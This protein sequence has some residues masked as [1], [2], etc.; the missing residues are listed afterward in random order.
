MVFLGPG[1]DL[2]LSLP[3]LTSVTLPLKQ[4]KNK[5]LKI[6]QGREQSVY[7]SVHEDLSF[8]LFCFMILI[9]TH[10]CLPICNPTGS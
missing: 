9:L 5:S 6:K 7:N 3:V 1:F 10:S 2:D 8:G 4:V